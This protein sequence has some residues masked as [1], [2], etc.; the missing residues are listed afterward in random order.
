M[1]CVPSS[2]LPRGTLGL[3]V[4]Q[5]LLGHGVQIDARQC[6]LKHGL[7][8][9][10]VALSSPTVPRLQV[11]AYAVVVPGQGIVGLRRDPIVH[12][13]GV[14]NSDETVPECDVSVEER[15][16]HTRLDGLDPQ[17]SLAE[18]DGERVPVDPVDAV[19]H[20]LA[21][22]T[23]AGLLVEGVIAGLDA[24]DLGGQP[25]RSR[26]QEVARPAGR[27]QHPEIEN[28]APG[29]FGACGNGPGNHGIK[30]CPYEFAD[31]ARRRV[32]RTAQLSRRP[33]GLRPA[34]IVSG[35]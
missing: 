15:K 33:L 12:D 31:E 21:E 20:D 3:N 27:V 14:D 29:I 30:G 34:A 17:G 18:L 35:K 1:G 4:V 32:V 23:P 9:E 11:A 5:R 24:R 13:L 19:L 6:D 26:Q 2:R 7:L 25:P 22:C 8:V 10:Q 28:R 16:W